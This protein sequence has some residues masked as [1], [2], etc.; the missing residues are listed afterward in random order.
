MV[1]AE[2]ARREDQAL[3]EPGRYRVLICPLGEVVPITSLALSPT[4]PFDTAFDRAHPPETD[5]KSGQ[6]QMMDLIHDIT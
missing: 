3:A 5:G 1:A 2:A 6:D 4:Y